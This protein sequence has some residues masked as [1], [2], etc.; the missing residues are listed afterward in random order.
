MTDKILIPLI[1]NVDLVSYDIFDNTFGLDLLVKVRQTLPDQ[2]AN[3]I[4][5]VQPMGTNTLD[6]LFENAKTKE[7]LIESGYKP[8][9]DLGFMWIKK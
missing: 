2:I 3:E 1:K 7:E 8:V 6:A 5:G 9:S 4:I